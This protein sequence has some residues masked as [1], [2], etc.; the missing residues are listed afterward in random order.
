[1]ILLVL[2]CPGP[3]SF[4]PLCNDTR[5]A[6]KGWPFGGAQRPSEAF[7]SRPTSL[8]LANQEQVIPAHPGLPSVTTVQRLLGPGPAGPAAA[9]Q[10][11][12]RQPARLRGGRAP[13]PR[14][15]VE[16]YYNRTVERYGPCHR[17]VTRTARPVIRTRNVTATPNGVLLRR[18]TV[19]YAAARRVG[20]R[21]HGTTVRYGPPGPGARRGPA[22][23][24][25]YS[26]RARGMIAVLLRDGTVGLTVARNPGD[27]MFR[28]RE[29]RRTRTPGRARLMIG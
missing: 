2:E 26:D 10:A 16:P 28:L 23:G 27:G 20:H 6:G 11:A 21:R 9:A 18:R 17:R 1:M 14:R 5:M 8:L 24:T 3:A 15:Q 4:M 25:R 7:C 19:P 13:R 22:A 12:R 29:R